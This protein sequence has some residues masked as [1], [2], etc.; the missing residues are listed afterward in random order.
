MSFLVKFTLRLLLLLAFS[1]LLL[2][3]GLANYDHFQT[4][5]A[6]DLQSCLKEILKNSNF[7]LNHALDLLL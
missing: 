6:K 3:I 2:E 5:P 7:A 1:A 4:H